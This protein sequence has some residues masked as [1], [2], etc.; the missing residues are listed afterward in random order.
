LALAR[1]RTKKF[2]AFELTE[3]A[4][5]YKQKAIELAKEKSLEIW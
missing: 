2:N 4:K 5:Y 1:H 3:I